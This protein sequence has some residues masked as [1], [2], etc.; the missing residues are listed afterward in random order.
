MTLVAAAWLAY[1]VGLA[2]V[3]WFRRAWLVPLV[4]ALTFYIAPLPLGL[5]SSRTPPAGHYVVMGAKIVPDVAIYVLLDD[6]RSQP[7]YYRLPYS[8]KTASRLQD[9]MDR[10]ADGHHPPGLKVKGDGSIGIPDGHPH[11]ADP[12]KHPQAPLYSPQQ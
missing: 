10:N 12:P 2:I 6:G 3:A 7:R 1:V 4:A 9:Q 5:P 8:N 11:R